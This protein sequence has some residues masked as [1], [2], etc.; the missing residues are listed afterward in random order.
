MLLWKNNAWNVYK[1]NG[2]LKLIIAGESDKRFVNEMAYE[3]K[4]NKVIQ[5]NQS[6]RVT[7]TTLHLRSL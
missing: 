2:F 4:N 6:W 3:H 1:N 5:Q 7:W